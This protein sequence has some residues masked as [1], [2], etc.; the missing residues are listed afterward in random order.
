M[1]K[2]ILLGWA[3]LLSEYQK[4]GGPW[5]LRKCP[6][7]TKSTLEPVHRAALVNGTRWQPGSGHLC[8]SAALTLEKSCSPSDLSL[9][10]CKLKTAKAPF[11]SEMTGWRL[12]QGKQSWSQEGPGPSKG[13]SSFWHLCGFLLPLKCC[14]SLRVHKS[15]HVCKERHGR[16][17]YAS[18]YNK[19]VVNNLY[20]EYNLS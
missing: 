18:P 13:A 6:N 17:S 14:I 10:L 12:W 3:H 7:R 2:D 1:T 15:W 8:P 4:V 5:D 16:N 19:H 20:L 11:G 9:F